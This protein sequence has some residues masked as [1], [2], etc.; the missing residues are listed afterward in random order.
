MLLFF[1]VGCQ[2]PDDN[3]FDRAVGEELVFGEE[4][5]VQLDRGD[6]GQDSDIDDLPTILGIREDRN[7]PPP[8]KSQVVISNVRDISALKNMPPNEISVSSRRVPFEA[9]KKDNL[10][11]THNLKDL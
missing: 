3:A 7:A 6:D 11:L 5:Q 10:Y 2:L 4:E 8:K 1:V 9:P